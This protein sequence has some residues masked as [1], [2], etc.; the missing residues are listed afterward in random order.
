M[1]RPVVSPIT[2]LVY[3]ELGPVVRYSDEDTGWTTLLWLDAHMRNLQEIYDL[4]RDRP[5]EGDLPGWAIIFDPDN[6]PA[7]ALRYGA[8]YV[9]RVLHPYMSEETMRLRYKNPD[10][11][12][13]SPTALLAD[14]REYLVGE[15]RIYLQERPGGNAW[16]FVI[17]TFWEDLPETDRE[18]TNIIANPDADNGT[19]GV[20]ASYGTVTAIANAISAGGNTGGNIW[21][22]VSDGS[23]QAMLSINQII[24]AQPGS[25]WSGYAQMA[26]TVAG[27]DFHVEIR[28]FDALNNILATP[29]G[30]VKVCGVNLFN[31]ATLEGAVAPVGTDRVVL[32]ARADGAAPANGRINYFDRF[33]LAPQKTLGTQLWADGDTSVPPDW[34]WAWDGAANASA[35]HRIQSS[36]ILD[37]IKKRKPIGMVPTLNIIQGGDYAALLAA[38]ASYQEVFTDFA[39]YQAV[40]NNPLQT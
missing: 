19:S 16:Q 28:F 17:S 8:Q 29:S 24:S 35:S 9:G 15:K 3:E 34:V 27:Q 30:A 13:G 7:N 33:R 2:E 4:V 31:E 12:R 1:D 22:H 37:R 40:L 36:I 20:A 18:R 23:S 6:A 10:F 25:V 38:H 21:R 26:P 5:E 32:Q 11:R 39:N 14:V